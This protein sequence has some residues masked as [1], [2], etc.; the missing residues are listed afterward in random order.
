VFTGIVEEVGKVKAAVGGKLAISAA[1]VLQETKKGDSIAV[2]GVCLT[3]TEISSGAFSMDVMPETLRRSNLGSLRP[4][5]P[6]HLERALAWGGRIGGH[7]V[8][9]H[10]DGKGRLIS[11]TPENEA[12]RLRFEAP[13]DIMRYVV[14]KGFIAVDGVS[15]TVTE[16]DATSFE[17]SLVAYTL[18]NTGLGQRRPGYEANLEVDIL[19]KYVEQLMAQL[20]PGITTEFLAEHGFLARQ[21]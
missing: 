13:K 21:G 4:G 12:L 16:R 8:Q 11:A 7:L 3:A 6:V 9:G 19:A 20:S 14:G 17:V 10:I 2:N 18:H 1:T 15:L 5:D